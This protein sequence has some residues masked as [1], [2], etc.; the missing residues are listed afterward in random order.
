MRGTFSPNKMQPFSLKG[1]SFGCTDSV[2]LC[3]LN[4]WSSV[5]EAKNRVNDLRSIL[6]LMSL[7]SHY[8]Y[9]QRS[10]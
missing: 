10:F 1:I 7:A 2:F 5:S 6:A 4:F 3:Y 9:N 8:S